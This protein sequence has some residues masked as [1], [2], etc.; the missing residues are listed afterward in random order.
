MGVF[1]FILQ[2]IRHSMDICEEWCAFCLV[3]EYHKPHGHNFSYL[4]QRDIG[5][6]DDKS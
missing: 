6:S 3:D 2:W 5:E 1:G 4:G